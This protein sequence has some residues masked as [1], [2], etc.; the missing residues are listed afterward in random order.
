MPTFTLATFN[1]HYGLR[2]RGPRMDLPGHSYDVRAACKRI[3]ADV[4]VFQELWRPDE[5]D[6]EI[7]NVARELGYELHQAPLCRAT[8]LP[9]L[10]PERPGHGSWGLGVLTRFPVLESRRL[11]IGGIPFDGVG[12]RDALQLTLGI[13]GARVDVVDLHASARVPHGPLVHIQRLRSQL[14]SMWSNG[15]VAGDFNCWGPPV[16][17]ILTGWRR[18]HTGATW[19]AHRPHSQLDHIL[20]SRTVEVV[21]GEVLP[22]VGSDHRPV[23]AT[24]RVR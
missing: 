9:R 10:R 23:R 8:T 19:P 5:G 2:P 13:D 11:P 4:I 1:L 17:A 14:P 3:D 20:V 16:T 12:N 24:L 18:A 15:I 7:D 22:D 21:D 6:T